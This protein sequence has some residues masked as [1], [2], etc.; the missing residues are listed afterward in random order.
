MSE[1]SLIKLTFSNVIDVRLT[2]V[3]TMD[4]SVLFSMKMLILENYR[5]EKTTV[6]SVNFTALLEVPG[7]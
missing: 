4:D 1:D 3:N 2:V 5:L 6:V 7:S